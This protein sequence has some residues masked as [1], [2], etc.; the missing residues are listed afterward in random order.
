MAAR[1]L[2]KADALEDRRGLAV[3]VLEREP[4]DGLAVEVGAGRDG[5]ERDLA[6]QVEIGC[7]ALADR[8]QAVEVDGPLLEDD[9]G[10]AQREEAVAA[11]PRMHRVV[12]I[13]HGLGAHRVD[14]DGER[15]AGAGILSTG[16]M[17]MFVTAG[18]RPQIRKRLV[19]ASRSSGSWI[20]Q[21]PNARRVP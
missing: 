14:D 1:V 17:W 7:G 20:W 12:G 19:W 2:L 4:L 8:V 15:A 9:P 16:I 11:R 21:S 3:E 13:A 10:H 6:D 18:L 5:V